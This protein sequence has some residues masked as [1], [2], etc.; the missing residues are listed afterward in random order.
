MKSWRFH[1]LFQLQAPVWL[2][3]FP[4][5]LAFQS[6]VEN[7]QSF[8]FLLKWWYCCQTWTKLG[9]ISWE[10][11]IKVLHLRKVS[12]KG[13]VVFCAFHHISR[14]ICVLY[15]VESQN[16]ILCTFCHTS[17]SSR[18]KLCL[19]G[20]N[21]ALAFDD[22]WRGNIKWRLLRMHE[23]PWC[24]FFCVPWKKM[25]LA[26]QIS[27]VP[28]K[29]VEPVKILVVCQS[30]SP[31]SPPL[32]HYRIRRAGRSRFDRCH[33]EFEW[34]CVLQSHAKHLTFMYYSVT[35]NFYDIVYCKAMQ[36]IVH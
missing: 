12:W 8:V 27:C 34:H 31:S 25:G 22:D 7:L 13:L 29:Y 24:L 11:E 10:F 15:V 2:D 17:W 14:F 19:N 23:K 33:T 35:H 30:P 6:E 20:L 36:N 3:S 5:P 18:S 32:H 16:M 28:G 26:G 9:Q 4:N 1:L 21:S